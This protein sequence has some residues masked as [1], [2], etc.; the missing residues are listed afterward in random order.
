ME[1]TYSAEILLRGTENPVYV[2]PE[3]KLRGLLPNSYI[4]VS[5][6]VCSKIGRLTL[7]IYKLLT[8]T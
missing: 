1:M 8:Y 7:G 3:M 6:S 4:H 5:V 2:F